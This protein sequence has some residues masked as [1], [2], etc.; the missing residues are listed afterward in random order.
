[1][2]LGGPPLVKMAIDEDA[3]EE[4][5]GGAEMHARISGLADYLAED[6]RDAL[7]IGRE[8][9]GAPATGAS[10]GH[11]PRPR[12]RSPRPT[13]PTSCSASPA[14]TS[15]S[16]STCAR[17]IAR[18]VDGSRFEEFK[19]LYGASWSPAGRDLARLPG[20]RSS[21]TTGSCS[22]RSRRR[23]RS[24][25]SCATGRHADPVPAEHHRLHGRHPLRAGR[26]H[27]GRRQA[28]Q[29]GVQ[30]DGPAP[31]ADGRRLATAPATTAWPAGRTTRGSSSPGPTTASP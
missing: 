11:G 28:D 29:R 15:G 7:R 10:S 13:T 24:S 9:V 8:I 3:D 27:Q 2:F 21:P 14:P 12:A 18:I 31:H 19:P 23:A 26:H 25:S 16:R 17:C 30:L 6:E 20:R 5:L 22:A 4:E 1:M